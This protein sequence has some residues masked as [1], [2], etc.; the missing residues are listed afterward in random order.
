M[1]YHCS[2]L[3]SFLNECNTDFGVKGT[4]ESQTK[5]NQ[6]RLSNIEI[7][8][9]KVEQCPTES[10]NGAVVVRNHIF[11]KVRNDLKMCMNKNLESIFVE[12]INTNNKDIVVGCVY[13]HPSM[14]SNEFN[15]HFFSILNEKLLLEKNKEITLIITNFQDQTYTCSLKSRIT[16]PARL[17]L[18]SK[19]LIDNIFSTNT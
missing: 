19:T 6:K 5:R 17:S 7:T 2:D 13:F 18:H 15:K 3:H 16:L 14:D 8:T 12:I 11:T 1:S 10:S 4:T 9:Y